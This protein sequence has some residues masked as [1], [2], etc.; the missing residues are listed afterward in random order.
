LKNEIFLKRNTKF[1]K[2]MPRNCKVA[3]VL[4]GE[5]ESLSEEIVALVRLQNPFIVGHFSEVS[6]NTKYIFLYLGPKG[7]MS[8]YQEVGKCISTLFADDVCLN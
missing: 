1:M 7:N 6:L 2:K 4:V 3:N 5:L 8:K